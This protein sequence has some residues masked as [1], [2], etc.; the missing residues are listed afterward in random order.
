M[1]ENSEQMA[2]EI[3]TTVRAW[4]SITI[5]RFR[6]SIAK[7][8][9]QSKML[10]KSFNGKIEKDANGFPVSVSIGFLLHGRFVDM[11]VGRGFPIGGR[12][13][14]AFQNSR[15]SLGQLNNKPDRKPKKWYSPVAYSE[16]SK[17]RELLMRKYA[18]GIAKVTEVSL[19]GGDKLT[20]NIKY[21]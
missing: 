15:N 13:T 5:K 12:R 1:P 2:A 16:L 11:G 17:L 18:T 9:I 8:G 3:N 19:S 14:E 4:L 10:F 21:K 6:Q 20:I 7:E